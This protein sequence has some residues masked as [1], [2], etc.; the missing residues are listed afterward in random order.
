MYVLEVVS[1]RAIPAFEHLFMATVQEIS[2]RHQ[3][4]SYQIFENVRRILQ[5]V[6]T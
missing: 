3:T 5:Y 1:T 2:V 6:Q 4:L